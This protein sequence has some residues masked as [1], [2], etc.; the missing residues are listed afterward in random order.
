MTNDNLTQVKW[1]SEERR[2]IV[3]FDGGVTWEDYNTAV[4]NDYKGDYQRLL[5]EA[6]VQSFRTT[7]AA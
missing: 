6:G 1:H 7:I 2:W 3:T 5:R 4:R